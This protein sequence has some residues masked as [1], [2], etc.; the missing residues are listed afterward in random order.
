M[1]KKALSS[2]GGETAW[3]LSWVELRPAAAAAA[4]VHHIGLLQA[5]SRDLILQGHHRKVVAW[6]TS[7]ADPPIPAE[8]AWKLLETG[9][10][11]F[12]LNR[13]RFVMECD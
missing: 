8:A 4:Q 7:A 3:V 10:E 11:R 6:L 1:C 5:A 9:R 13:S 12:K 2:S